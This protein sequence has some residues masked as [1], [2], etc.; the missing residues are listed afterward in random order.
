M[1][2]GTGR[3]IN[4]ENLEITFDGVEYLEES[5]MMKKVKEAFKDVKDIVPGGGK[6]VKTQIAGNYRNI[7]KI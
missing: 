6:N 1:T 7:S 2:K 3:I 4:Y 5:S